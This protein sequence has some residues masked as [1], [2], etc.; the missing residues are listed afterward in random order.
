MPCV[1]AGHHWKLAF[2]SQSAWARRIRQTC[3]YAPDTTG[4]VPE[5][6]CRL[7]EKA[8]PP[9]FHGHQG[10]FHVAT[11]AWRSPPQA[12]LFP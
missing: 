10:I 11:Q 8:A 7:R 3:P 1:P 2:G 4:G 12:S 9:S 6:Q 5:Y